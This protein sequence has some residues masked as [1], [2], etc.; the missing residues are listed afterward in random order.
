MHD[1]LLTAR[2]WQKVA[3]GD[4]NKCWIWQGAKGKGLNRYGHFKYPGG[5]RA[6]RFALELKL[7]RALLPSEKS[8]HQCDNPPCCNP[9]HL[10]LGTQK[11][12][13]LDMLQKKRGGWKRGEDCYNAILNEQA[14]ITLRKLY[15]SGRTAKFLAETFGLN[16]RVVQ[17]AVTGRTWKHVGGPIRGKLESS[18]G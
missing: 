9:D 16:I 13:I 3:I 10:F 12:N 6:H 7:G 11:D 4:P 1:A 15:A 5:Q 18:V 8:L 17:K 14:V 2:F